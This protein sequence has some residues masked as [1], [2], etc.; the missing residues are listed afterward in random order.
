MIKE[1]RLQLTKLRELTKF[2]ETEIA[3]MEKA[4]EFK[5]DYHNRG[6]EEY[7]QQEQMQ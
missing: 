6:G 1:Y 7:Y 3:R 2:L 5:Q 4:T